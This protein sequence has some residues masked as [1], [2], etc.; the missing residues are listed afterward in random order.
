M[1]LFAS[2]LNL[3]SE[4]CKKLNIKDVYSLHRVVYSLFD[5]VRTDMEK[6]A[7]ISSGIQ[8]VDKGGDAL[9]RKIL[10]LSNRKP[11]D[12]IDDPYIHMVTKPM[13]E[14]FL[15]HPRYRFEV[16]V[17]PTCR[18]PKSGK[19]VPVKGRGEIHTWFVRRS[20]D[21][22]GFKVSQPHLCVGN[23]EVIQFQSKH[24]ITLQQA[25]ISGYLDVVDAK[26]FSHSVNF[27]IGRGRSFGCGLLQLVPILGECLF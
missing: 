1:N 9:G 20:E 17:N 8:W 4:A 15:S 26:D 11:R 16:I 14:N 23:I 5:D 13:P 12:Q 27:G 21:H 6:S 19:L 18:H 25:K 22:W 3:D 2:M 24:W 10:I 7:N